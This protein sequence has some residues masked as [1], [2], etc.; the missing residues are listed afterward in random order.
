MATVTYSWE[1][2]GG[3]FFLN[4]QITAGDQ[5]FPAIT[6][7]AN[8]SYFAVWDPGNGD[9]VEGRIIGPDGTPVTS[10]FF[11]NSTG[12][13]RQWEASVAGLNNGNAVVTFTD[14]SVDA[15]G[16]IRARLVRPDGSFVALD[17]AVADGGTH[18]SYSTVAALADGGFVVTWTRYFTGYDYDIRYR[19]YNADGTA[20]NTENSTDSSTSIGTDVQ[21]VAGLTGGGFVIAWEQFAVNNIYDHTVWFQLYDADGDSVGSHVQM[22]TDESSH[23]QVA[24]LKDGGFAAVYT[25]YGWNGSPDI[26]LRIYN[27]DGSARTSPILANA[28]ADTAGSQ[29]FPQVAVLSNGFIVVGWLNASYFLNLQAFSPTGAALGAVGPIIN[30]ALDFDLAAL[31]G[32]LIANARW[33]S[34]E[35]SGGDDSVRSSVSEFVRTTTGTSASETLTGDSLRDIMHGGGGNDVIDGKGGADTMDGGAGD[36]V[37]IVDNTGDQVIEA[38][39][40]GTAD[41]VLVSISCTLA[42][43]AEIER[44]GTTN[45]AGTGAINLTGNEF[46]Q[47]V[48]GNAG[49]N[50]LFGNGGND[51]LSGNAG[52]DTLSGG[53][54]ADHAS[55]G[56]NDTVYGGD[57]EDTLSGDDGDD[58]VSGGAGNDVVNGGTGTD[59]VYGGVG[60]DSMNGGTG[61]DL[62]SGGAGNDAMFGG[63]QGDTL[64]G[65]ADNDSISGDAGNDTLSG[66]AGNDVLRGGANSD[67]LLGAAGTDNLDGG[68]GNDTLTGGADADIFVFAD[69]YQ[70][71]IIQ[72]FENDIDTIRLDDNLWGG[73][74]TVAQVLSIYAHQTSPGVVDFDFGGGD[75][76]RVVNGHGITVAQL[77]DDL[78]I[79]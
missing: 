38:V 61:V 69:G 58:V 73:G 22:D 44:F 79:V 11:V 9:S 46:A 45:S 56:G 27:A 20:R 33:S 67:Q 52:N 15:T 1:L 70:A 31:A 7:L 54:G 66:G 62:L 71:D 63:D 17:F 26:T 47:A 43:G 23:V 76:L 18:D 55:G 41:Q 60:N 21:Q 74:K 2:P 8:G 57:G 28:G 68:T 12:P 51:T 25:D 10:E 40:D 14:E 3:S 37:F 34:A 24:A 29:Y 53:L 32:G 16:D 64:Y 35:D 4:D 5:L 78:T 19:L 72:G 48:E 75:T 65:A 30:A 49:A 50:I 39:N 77:Q 42:I 13:F 36:D 6:A 59:T